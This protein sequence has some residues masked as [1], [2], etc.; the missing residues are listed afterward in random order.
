MAGSYMRTVCIF[1]PLGRDVHT[2]L[3]CSRRGR[4]DV[5]DE[6]L[7]LSAVGLTGAAS[8]VAAPGASTTGAAAGRATCKMRP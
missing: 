4:G 7:K 3:M 6:A 2:R 1:V 8:A 5:G